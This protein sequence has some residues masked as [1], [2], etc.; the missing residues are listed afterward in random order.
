MKFILG[1]I[2]GFLFRLF[3]DIISAI[4]SKL[5]ASSTPEMDNELTINEV[6]EKIKI[7]LDNEDYENAA[8]YRDALNKRR[9]LSNQN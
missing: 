7:Y 3:I 9:K 4:G 8:I 2:C 5:F 1:L 6:E